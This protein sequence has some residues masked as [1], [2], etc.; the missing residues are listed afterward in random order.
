[1]LRKGIE[2]YGFTLLTEGADSERLYEGPY[3]S[4]VPPTSHIAWHCI[5]STCGPA[6]GYWSATVIAKIACLV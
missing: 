1:M 5:S 3:E 4:R 2:G 6:Q